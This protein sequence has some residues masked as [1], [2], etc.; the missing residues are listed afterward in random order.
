M[1]YL[2]IFQIKFLITKLRGHLLKCE[3]LC[4]DYI[5]RYGDEETFHFSLGEIY[6]LEGKIHKSIEEFRKT[7]KIRPKSLENRLRLITALDKLKN[8]DEVIYEA[9]R[10]I[11]QLDNYKGIWQNF[12][13]NTFGYQFYWYLAS[14]WFFK[15]EFNKAIEIYEKT[16]SADIKDKDR[17]YERLGFAYFQIGRREKALQ[18][19]NKG[20]KLNSKNEIIRNIL[21]DTKA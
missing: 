17:V 6:L 3:N 14:A 5:N 2:I 16:L 10:A 9:E 18:V 20:L 7:V 4:K 15:K 1:A 12:H 19:L 11:Q 13:F 21:T 8:Y